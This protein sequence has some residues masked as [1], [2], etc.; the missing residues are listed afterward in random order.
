[1]NDALIVRELQGVTDLR[2]HLQR[3]AGRELARLLHLP[4]IQP[5][6]ILHDEIM[7]PAGD[8]EIIHAHDIGVVKPRQGAR[9]SGEPLRKTRIAGGLRRQDFQRHQPI[10]C[11]LPRSIHRPHAPGTGESPIAEK[12]PPTRQSRAGRNRAFGWIG[13]VLAPARSR[14]PP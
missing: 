12:G 10:Q 2:D 13:P 9:L 4:Q 6:D 1:V 11:R 7:Q 14:S 3:L 8:A 5:L